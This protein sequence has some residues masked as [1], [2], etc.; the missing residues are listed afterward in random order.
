MK[1]DCPL[2][3]RSVRAP[4]VRAATPLPSAHRVEVTLRVNGRTRRATVPAATTLLRLLR[5]ELHL[6]GTK[7]GCG[8]GECGGCT[9]VVGGKP[10]R[11]CLILAAE[12]DGASVTTI[13]GL[14]PPGRLHAIQEAF[15][16]SGA[17]QCGYCSPGFV[18]A[19]WS[20]LAERLDP[21]RA[22]I[23][24]AF[25]GHLCRC[26]GYEAI[27]EAVRLAARW[28]REGRGCWSP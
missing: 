27:F 7:E 12:C 5:D 16:E 4:S 8:A 25:G 21:T 11:S 13:E 1:P 15:I 23:E 17:I 18:L 22:E 24:E 19:A 26:T 10:L 9:V 28:R 20:L 14:A 6:T 2:S 3:L